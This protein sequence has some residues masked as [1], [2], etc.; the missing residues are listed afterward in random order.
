MNLK[1]FTLVELVVV[2]AMI[3]V[4]ALT[5]MV[6][7]D[8]FISRAQD[9]KAEEVVTNLQNE[10]FASTSFTGV[11]VN[12]GTELSPVY[13][14]VVYDVASDQ[15]KFYKQSSAPTEE[16]SVLAL[17]KVFAGIVDSD[18]WDINPLSSSNEE[19]L[20]IYYDLD[21]FLTIDYLGTF[22]GQYVWK[23]TYLR[24]TM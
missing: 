18:V 12:V 4:L 21:A 9:A 23:P 6:G 16:E 11:T 19:V 7:Y 2:M 20:S 22:G 1:G 17:E 3:S 8:R 14:K 15:F 24:T 13:V 5:S 10:V